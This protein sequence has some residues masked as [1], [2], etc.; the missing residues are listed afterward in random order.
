MAHGDAVAAKDDRTSAAH[1]D[2]KPYS[3]MMINRPRKG[4]DPELAEPASCTEKDPRKIAR[5]YQIEL[6]KKALT[7]NVIVYLGTGCGKTHIAVLLIY[8]MGHLIRKPQKQI[9]VF[10]AT[11][12]ALAEQ[13][14]KA[15]KDSIDF[16][17]GIF[18]GG[19]KGLSNHHNWEKE[20]QQYEVFV[21]TP[22]ILLR[23]L[24]HCF[25]TMEL[26]ALLIL[27][28]CH[29]AQAQ[30]NHPYAEIMK[31]FYDTHVQNRPRIF[32]MT[33]SPI[34]GKGASNPVDMPKCINSLENTL[35]AK[36]YTVEEMD[37]LKNFFTS[38]KVKIY[39]YG[40]V[41]NTTSTIHLTYVSRL[42]EIKSQCVSLLS[43]NQAASFDLKSLQLI[44]KSIR[45]VHDNLISCLENLGIWGALQACQI[46]LSGDMSE[47]NELIETEVNFEGNSLR[48]SY[49]SKAASVLSAECVKDAFQSDLSC[50]EV[51]KEPFFSRK[52]LRL[53]GI[54][55]TF[56]LQTNMKC[57]IFVNRI[58]NARSLCYILQNLKFL[59]SWKCNF[60]VG[61]HSGLKSASRQTMNTTI[62]MFRSDKLNLLVATKVGEEGLDIQT[63][64][65][66]IRFDL[67]ETVASF[68]QSRGRARMPHSE[69][70]FLVDS[71]NQKEIDLVNNFLNDENRMNN[72]VVARSSKESYVEPLEKVYRVDSSGACITAGYSVTLLHRYCS[73][74]P[75]D[76]HFIPRPEFYFFD[77]TEGAVCHL[78]FPANA[79]INLVVSSP[80]SSIEEAKKDASL[81]ACK[82]LHK[83]GIFNDYL[84]PNNEKDVKGDILSVKDGIDYSND[85]DSR[86]ELHEML[87]PSALAESCSNLSGTVSLYSYFVNFL[88]AQNDRMYKAFG[89][90]IKKALSEDALT[91]KID[92]HLSHGRSVITEFIP[93][94]IIDFDK[95]KLLQAHNFQ[96]MYFK[97]ILERSEFFSEYVPL[98]KSFK[99]QSGVLASYLLLPVLNQSGNHTLTVDWPAILRCLSSPIFKAPL[100]VNGVVAPGTNLKLFNCV[101]SLY[102]IKDS[103]VFVPY[104]S[105]FFFVSDILHDKNG[106]SPYKGPINIVEHFSQKCS[107]N[108]LCPEQPLLKAKQLFCLH[109]LL[110]DRGQGCTEAQELEEHFFEIPPELCQLKILGFS[111]DMGSSL[112]LLPSVMH[113]LE[114][115][116]VAAELKQLFSS[117][118]AEGSEITVPRILEA[119]TTEKCNERISLERLEVLGDAF[120]KFSIG[121]HL[122]L[123]YDALDEG[124]LTRMRSKTVSNSNLYELAIKK[125]LQVLGDLMESCIGA[126]YLDTGFDLKYVWRMMHSL[127]EPVM[128]FSSFQISPIRELKELCQ[129]HKW[130]VEFNTTKV[131]NIFSVEAVVTGKNI[132]AA[133]CVANHSQKDGIRNAAQEVCMRLKVRILY[134]LVERQKRRI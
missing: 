99:T 78:L 25:M 102:D 77:D 28:E 121:R 118:F 60:L 128:R 48:N 1:A 43:Q 44:K 83:L 2:A 7:E 27:D 124:G 116:L 111:K 134:E 53:L 69:Y 5:R 105:A 40:P 73:M 14:A 71:G 56:R 47:H 45:R 125:N 3:T 54:L 95:E 6:C 31:V 34:V 90:F 66:V 104:K 33:A 68:I 129:C 42:T 70:A 50:V 35:D 19:T 85:V 84:L 51:L 97:V 103:L 52:L 132:S 89:L 72:E 58:V 62:D 41:T 65:L 114:N 123:K 122:F 55:S 57:I 22:Q 17:V 106:W 117:S 29:H 37:E 79:S 4:K 21:M 107:I 109:N 38:P 133:T 130:K 81:K 16:K 59:A 61:V 46:L 12:V 9:C 32:G 126:V 64:C 113:R 92:L 98:G 67:P 15:I 82:E 36:I 75:H 26:I 100:D 91:L 108:L 112:S 88:P 110:C 76:E 101:A 49:I 30:S 119:L 20:I 115:V 131:G 13:Q 11:T 18:C 39:H 74:L 23:N 94:G 96:E 24:N 93:S 63:C 8:E 10:L 87:V 80:Q 86:V 120:L 127:L